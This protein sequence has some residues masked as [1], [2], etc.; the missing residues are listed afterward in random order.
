[1]IYRPDFDSLIEQK[2]GYKVTK[3]LKSTFLIFYH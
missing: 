1:M 3:D 2:N